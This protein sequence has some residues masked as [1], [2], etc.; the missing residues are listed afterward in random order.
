VG[1][2][3]EEKEQVKGNKMVYTDRGKELV[4][5]LN[6]IRKD[7]KSIINALKTDMGKFK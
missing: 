2:A 5:E 6:R 7:P 1:G 4:V 3:G